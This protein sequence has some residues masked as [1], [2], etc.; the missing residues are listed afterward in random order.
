MWL[1]DLRGLKSR[2]RLTSRIVALLRSRI[3]KVKV[4]LLPMPKGG[5]N[6]PI[7]A[8]MLVGSVA[9]QGRSDWSADFLRRFEEQV[10][11]EGLGLFEEAKVP[12][13]VGDL[14]DAIK[15]GFPD[16]R[17][18]ELSVVPDR[19]V[20]SRGIDWNFRRTEICG[21]P[22]ATN[23]SLVVVGRTSTR[24]IVVVGR[25]LQVLHEVEWHRPET[26]ERALI[27]AFQNPLTKD[28]AIRGRLEIA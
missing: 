25:D 2:Y 24:E 6:M 5:E 4:K 20:V 7:T 21:D 27:H 1:K 9:P 12:D 3:V 10:E 11:E 14:L 18:G 19:G 16:A 15:K 23:K 28:R 22:H 8:E 17:L 26:L 13:L